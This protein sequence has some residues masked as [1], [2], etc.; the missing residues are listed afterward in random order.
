MERNIIAEAIDHPGRAE[1]DEPARMS[2]VGAATEMLDNGLERLSQQANM[3]GDRLGNYLR[4]VDDRILESQPEQAP[5]PAAANIF[6][7]ASVVNRV[8]DELAELRNRFE[9]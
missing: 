6:R 2:E 7:A 4:P 3:L 1:D 5:V 9:G 8:A